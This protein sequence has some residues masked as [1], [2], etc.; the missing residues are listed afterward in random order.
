MVDVVLGLGEAVS[1]DNRCG[2]LGVG[3][4]LG[5][6]GGDQGWWVGLDTRIWV[7]DGW[8]KA[9]LAMS[10]GYPIRMLAGTPFIHPSCEKLN[11]R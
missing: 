4:R 10:F 11:F 8:L 6:V 5:G 9:I 1:G 7:N 2:G 3:L